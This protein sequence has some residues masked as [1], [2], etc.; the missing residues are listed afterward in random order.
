MGWNLGSLPQFFL[1]L[2]LKFSEIGSGPRSGIS[3]SSEELS[4]EKVSLAV[5]FPETNQVESTINLKE[6]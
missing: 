5:F 2:F 1:A 4:T 6:R 3:S